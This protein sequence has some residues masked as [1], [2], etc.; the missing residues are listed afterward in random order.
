MLP[1]QADLSELE[2]N[3]LFAL[4]R[5][6][7]P[8]EIVRDLWAPRAA[9]AGLSLDEFCSTAESLAGRKL[10]GRFSTFLEHSKPTGTG[11]QA[12]RHSALV[13]WAVPKSAEFA[14][15]GEIGRHKIL[16]HCYWRE[17]GPEF[18]NLNIMGVIHGLEEEKVLA[19]KA[20]IDDHLRECGF[21]T[22]YSAVLWSVRADIKP[23]EIEPAAYEAWCREMDVDPATLTVSD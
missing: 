1:E 21:P 18:G 20:A 14:A 5:E 15:G 8:E 17:A 16:T 2:W 12:N 23:S 11:A 4:K 22:S 10:L 7:A 6:F 13:Q 19:H 9:A 3:V